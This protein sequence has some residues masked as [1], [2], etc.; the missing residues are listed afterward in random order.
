MG[1]RVRYLEYID[2]NI[3]KNFGHMNGLK[4]LELGDQVVRSKSIPEKTGKQYYQNR[5]V[6]HTSVDINERHG[7]IKLN[8]S[9][10]IDKKEWLNH[11]DVITNSGTT[12]HVEPY[13]SQYECFE[14][15]HNFLKVGG[16][17]IHLVPGFEAVKAL[18]LLKKNHCN[19]YYSKEFFETLANENNYNIIN[20]SIAGG[21]VCACLR[22]TEQSVFIKDRDLFLSG[23]TRQSGGIIYNIG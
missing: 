18:G 14:N 6:E 3:I 20:I 11:F 2:N 15:I 23:I 16:L 7:S 12:E 21:N 13:E 17:S 4:M 5:D 22:K 1:L 8:L 19:N 10:L 9:K